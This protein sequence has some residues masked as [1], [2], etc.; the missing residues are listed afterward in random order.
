M[1]LVAAAKPGDRVVIL[2]RFGVEHAGRCVM[3]FP[4]HLVLNMGG[5]HGKPGV[6]DDSNIVRIVAKK[7][8]AVAMPGGLIAARG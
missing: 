1:S 6:A 8:K 2:D 5:A 4:S 3:K 7:A